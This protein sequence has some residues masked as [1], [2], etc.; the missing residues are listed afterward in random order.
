[1]KRTH[2]LN[3]GLMV[4]ILLTTSCAKASTG[5]AENLFIASTPADDS[6]KSIFRIPIDK[7]IDFI[8]WSLTLSAGG[9]FNLDINYGEGQPNTN[10][11]KGGGEK[12]SFSGTYAVSN[13]IYELKS[14]NF[15]AQISLIKLNENLFHLLT[16]DGKLMVGNGG[17]SYTLTRK[18]ADVKYSPITWKSPLAQEI[19]QEVIYDGRTPCADFPEQSANCYKLKWRLTLFRDKQT[20]EPTV[21][22]LRGSLYNHETRQGKWTIKR[23]GETVIYQLDNSFSFLVG[24]ENVLFF[25]DRRNQLL[26]GNSDF[27]FTLNRKK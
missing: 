24:D 3:L 4:C 6:I 19:A 27:S 2:F 21:Y 17:W 16:S 18:D 26:T 5:V 10:G 12:L 25:L 14:G 15:S 1:M 8:R 11:F 9:S 20:N 22:A 23:D 7:K 13:N